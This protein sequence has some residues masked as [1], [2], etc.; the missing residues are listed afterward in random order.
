MD[1]RD[2]VDGVDELVEFFGVGD[3]RDVVVVTADRAL[4]DRVAAAGAT[5]KGPGWLLDQL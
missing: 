3:G 5:S 1:D 4:R 2:R